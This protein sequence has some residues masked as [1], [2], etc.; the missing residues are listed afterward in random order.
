MSRAIL[1]RAEEQGLAFTAAEGFT[2][3]AG[4]GL[5]ADLD[6][7]RYYAGNVQ[8]M[9]EQGLDLQDFEDRAQQLANDGKTPLYFAD[10]TRVLG[11]IEV[12]D[13]IKPTSAQAIETFKQM[14]LEVVM[15]TGDN[16]RTAKAIQR[17]LG[18]DTVIAD[19]LPQDKEAHV[20]ALQAEGK[21]VAVVGDGINDAPALA[22]ADVGIA[23]GAGTDI[24]IESADIVLM[25]SDLKD[26]ATAIQLSRAVIRNIKLSLFWAFFYNTLGIP[27]AAGVFYGALGWRLSPMFGAAAMSLSSVC[28]VTNAL[29]LRGFKPKFAEGRQDAGPAEG[30]EPAAVTQPAAE[31]TEKAADAVVQAG[32]MSCGHC[33]SAVEKALLAVDGVESAAAELQGQTVRVRLAKPVSDQALLEAVRGAGYEALSVEREKGAMAPENKGEQGKMKKIVKVEGMMCQHCVAH[34]EKALRAVPGVESVEVS[35]ENK[36][37]VVTGDAADQALLDAVTDAGYQANGVEEA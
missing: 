14:G 15:I 22:R 34:V 25:K 11:L 6:G 4:R 28:V 2:A 7:V 32:G 5:Q 21:K 16:E 26:A 9:R 33:T 24:A 12:A 10:Q 30:I 27:L 13:T 31:R 20:R 35:L 1:Q 3:L 8:L 37:A 17:R 36:Q 18:I 29:R 19:V 23:I